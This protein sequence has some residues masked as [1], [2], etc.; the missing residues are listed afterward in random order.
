MLSTWRGYPQ[1]GELHGVADPLRRHPDS[2]L[3]LQFDHGVARR[4][5]VVDLVGE[6]AV[7]AAVRD[8][9][10]VQPWRGVVVDGHRALD[11]ITRAAAALLHCGPQAVL[12]HG[13]AAALHGCGAAN[14][15][16]V[17]VTVPRPVRVRS[18]PGLTVH[19][20][21][22]HPRDVTA[23]HGLAVVEL[24]HAVTEV[25]CSAQRWRALACLDQA[26]AS[27]G[28]GDDRAFA[29]TV[30]SRLTE[31]AST[32]GV[33]VAESLLRLGDGGAESPPESRLRLLVIDAGFPIPVTQ[34][35]IHDLAGVRRY[36]LDLGWDEL[37]IGMEY[38]GYAAHEGREAYDA[39]RDRD[40]AGRGWLIIRAR[41]EDFARPERLLHELAQAFARRGM[42]LSA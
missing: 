3:S 33:R 22:I 10:L 1:P 11:P 15:A 24:D 14:P 28:E 42:L 16:A 40:L 2:V 4:R 8:G 12:S 35:P 34:Y 17:H 5:D 20:G 7:R 25:L 6:S 30:G 31:R 23:L 27:C 21:I 41:K 32:R 19:R 38:D 13:T 29:H 37:R 18:G 39:A 9:V 26:L 36:R